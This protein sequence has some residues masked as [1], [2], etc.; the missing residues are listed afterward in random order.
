MNFEC[1]FEGRRRC[2]RH[3]RRRRRRSR[4]VVILVRGAGAW[5]GQ[6]IFNRFFNG[7]SMDFP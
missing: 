5:G 3:R 2:G 7:L 6:L 4:M 1:I